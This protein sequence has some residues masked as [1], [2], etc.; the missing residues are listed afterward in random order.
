M[1]VQ[2][3]YDK[4][5][6]E[7]NWSFQLISFMYSEFDVFLLPTSCNESCEL[8]S[9]CC[10]AWTFR[11]SIC[12]FAEKK[13]IMHGAAK[14]QFITRNFILK[15]LSINTHN[16]FNWDPPNWIELCVLALN[17]EVTTKI[18]QCVVGILWDFA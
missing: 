3:N 1:I 9:Y 5:I 4:S 10:E 13:S 17:W 18:E 7:M 14:P 12:I 8:I 6:A 11:G 16:W 2:K 15:I